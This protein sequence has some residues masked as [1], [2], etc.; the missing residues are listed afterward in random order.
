MEDKS[1]GGACIRV[2]T[3]I[4]VGSKLSVQWRWEQF[5]GIAKY[6]RSEGRDYVVGIQRD[7]GIAVSNPPVSAADL[8]T[9][10]LRSDGTSRDAPVSAAKIQSPPPQESTPNEISVAPP[11]VETVPIVL[12]TK[13]PTALPP[14]EILHEID[15]QDRPRFSPSPR[16][17]TLRLAEPPA[18]RPF[19]RKESGMERKLMQRKWLGLAPWHN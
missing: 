11:R 8:V 10:P 19:R 15:A 14:R 13:G 12:N 2:K 9:V 17:D 16:Y 6:C 5:S 7:T 4:Q 3:P 18:K 1:A